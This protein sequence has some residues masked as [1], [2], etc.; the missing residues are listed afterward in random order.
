MKYDG[1]YLWNLRDHIFAWLCHEPGILEDKEQ[2]IPLQS[3]EDSS[4]PIFEQ[5]QLFGRVDNNI[6]TCLKKN[7]WKLYDEPILRKWME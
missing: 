6:R 7:R 3:K 1:F 2:N 4:L 5:N